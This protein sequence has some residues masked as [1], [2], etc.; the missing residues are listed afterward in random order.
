MVAFG[1]K[2]L[3][4]LIDVSADKGILFAAEY[5]FNTVP[6]GIDYCTEYY[7]IF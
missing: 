2:G 6:T 3:N 7:M 4:T 5:Q 1:F